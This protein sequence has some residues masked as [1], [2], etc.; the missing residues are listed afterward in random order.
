MASISDKSYTH[1]Y[2]TPISI[3]E[4]KEALELS[5]YSAL[6]QEQLN[7]ETREYFLQLQ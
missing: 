6:L 5:R 2:K 7:W 1:N 4:S 3:Y